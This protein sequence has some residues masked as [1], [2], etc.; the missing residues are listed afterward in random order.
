[1]RLRGDRLLDRFRPFAPGLLVNRAGLSG[2]HEGARR[3]TAAPAAAPPASAAALSRTLGRAAR[4]GRRRERLGWL[5]Q[6][7]RR[8]RGLRR[9]G[10]AAIRSRLA[11][12]VIIAILDG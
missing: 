9:S 12:D 5:G 8:R 2:P 4:L 10:I 1:M 11:D 3:G 6:R 7:W